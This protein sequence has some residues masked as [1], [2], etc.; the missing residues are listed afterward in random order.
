MCF[1]LY[2]HCILNIHVCRSKPHVINSTSH[3][4]V[5]GRKS[6]SHAVMYLFILSTS[7]LVV[8][9]VTKCGISFSTADKIM[10]IKTGIFKT[11]V[12]NKPVLHFLKNYMSDNDFT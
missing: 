3:D 2:K 1:Y 7:E 10:T 5:S 4:V 12:I 11:Y 6:Y 8:W 9:A